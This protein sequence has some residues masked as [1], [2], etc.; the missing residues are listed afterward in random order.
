MSAIDYF[1]EENLLPE[2][3]SDELLD[4]DNW[5]IAS[6]FI[7]YAAGDAFGAAHEFVSDRPAKIESVLLGKPDWPFG[8]VSDDTTLSLFRTVKRIATFTAG[9][10]SNYASSTWNV[11]EARGSPSDW[12][13]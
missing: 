5:A 2:S 9:T 10:R 7:A 6:A 1:F 8:G 12:R 4:G 11:G 13:Q 3:L